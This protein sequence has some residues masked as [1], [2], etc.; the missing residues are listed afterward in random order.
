MRFTSTFAALSSVMALAIS[1]SSAS[2]AADRRST[3]P[4]NQVAFVTNCTSTSDQPVFTIALDDGIRSQEYHSYVVD[5]FNK[6]GYT[7][8]FFTNGDNYDCLFKYRHE[9][10]KT[11]KHG[12]ALYGSH[13]WAH[14]NATAI[15]LEDWERDIELLELAY[16][17]MG[18]GR[19][20]FYRFPYGEH[21]DEHLVKLKERGYL[22]AVQWNQ[23][24]YDSWGKTK[25]EILSM[26]RQDLRSP[27]LPKNL[28]WLNH[29]TQ[30]VDVKQGLLNFEFK[31]MKKLG[32][33]YVDLP[34][35]LN[36]NGPLFAP[37]TEKE[38]QLASQLPTNDCKAFAAAYDQL[39]GPKGRKSL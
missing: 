20:Y 13:G 15:S 21:N 11:L 7:P 24:S 10:K 5:A 16:I 17:N 23:D 37:P 6:R 3:Q 38:R 33:K 9:I 39:P 27:A 4:S 34:Q 14:P 30:D 1:A 22:A 18:L 19:P 36:Y 12:Q 35:C 2:P 25:H 28:L 29:E 32:K 26:L 8:F 31:H